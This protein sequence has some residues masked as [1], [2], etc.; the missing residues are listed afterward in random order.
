IGSI[1][2]IEKIINEK[3]VFAELG[4]EIFDDYWRNYGQIHITDSQGKIKKITK[5]K[6]Y[7]LYRGK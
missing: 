2:N 5:L 1:K 4:E 3:G 7:L 6:E